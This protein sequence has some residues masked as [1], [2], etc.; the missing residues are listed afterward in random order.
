[1]QAA[2]QSILEACARQ[3]VAPGIHV[4][5]VDGEE[6]PR[7]IAAGFRFIACGLDSLFLMHGCRQVLRG[8]LA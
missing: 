1:M 7:R 2:Q 6:L 5:P 3:Q 4:V 8:V